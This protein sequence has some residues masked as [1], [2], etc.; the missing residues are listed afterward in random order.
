MLGPFRP[1]SSQIRRPPLTRAVGFTVIHKKNKRLRPHTHV[2]GYF[3]ESATFSFRI[4]LSSTR[5]RCI[6][7]TNH[8]VLNPSIRVDGQIRF[9]SGKKTLRIRKY[10]DT[11]RWGLS[12]ADRPLLGPV[13]TYPD[14]FESA[15]FS[16]WIQ[17]EFSIARPHVSAD[18][19]A[20]YT[21][22]V[23]TI[24]VSGKKTLRIQK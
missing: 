9:E 21:G 10:P 23:W 24:A 6:R 19:Y 2:S 15:T 1:R 22:Y 5:I 17:I 4:R 12:P 16:S 11:R 7:Q 3:S 18:S 8:N 14:I 20:G 13:H